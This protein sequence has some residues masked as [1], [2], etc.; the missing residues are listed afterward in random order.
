MNNY[1]YAGVT[2]DRNTSWVCCSEESKISGINLMSVLDNFAN[3]KDIKENKPKAIVKNK[4]FIFR[5]R[6]EYKKGIFY[7]I[8]FKINKDNTI[9]PLFFTPYP[10]KNNKPCDKI[11]KEI[12]RACEDT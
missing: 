10:C 7:N 9:S 12:N 8:A 1:D 2:E 5:T 4:V 3:K 6:L 11:V